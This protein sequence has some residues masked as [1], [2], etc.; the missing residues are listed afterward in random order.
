MRHSFLNYLFYNVKYSDA[1]M[2]SLCYCR[3]RKSGQP[4]LWWKVNAARYSLLAPL[5]RKWLGPPPSSVPSERVFSE[6]G[7]IYTPERHNLKEENAEKLCSLFY[8]LRLTNWD[9]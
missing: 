8:N 1:Q 4:L 2:L 3:C 6:V 9:Y 5:A 7:N